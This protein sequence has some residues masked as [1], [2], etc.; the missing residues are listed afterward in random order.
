[1]LFFFLLLSAAKG[2]QES[3]QLLSLHEPTAALEASSDNGVPM[4]VQVEAEYLKNVSDSVLMAESW[5]RNFVLPHYPRT[6]ISTIIVGHSVLCNSVEEDKLGLIL[7]SIKNIH[8]SLTRWGLE[9]EIKVAASFSSNCLS[10]EAETH[11]K[12]LLNLLQ[13]MGSPYVVNPPPNFGKWSDETSSLVKS[14][15]ESMKNMGVSGLKTVNVVVG[16][17]RKHKPSGRKLSFID[18][19]RNIVPFPPRPTPIAPYVSPPRS[20]DPA[21]AA[22]SPL[23]PLVGTVS[24]TPLSLPSLPPTAANPTNPPFLPH[25]APMA[26]PSSP[27][28]GLHLPPCDPSNGGGSVGAPV[29]GVH[30]GLWCVAKP[31]VPAETLQEAIDYACGEG[32]ADCEAISHGGS[33]YFPDTV[34]A[35]ASYAFNSYWQ[36]TKKHGGTCGFGGTAMLINSDPSK[37]SFYHY[38]D[39]CL[40]NLLIE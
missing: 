28:F 20:S 30:N 26:N 15:L 36:R 19:I 16:S 33:C 6:N 32:G 21:F 5:L 25:L 24:P 10:E 14:H 1:M 3:V 2:Q 18:I 4:A 8:S 7:P 40:F 37:T 34:V 29:A 27:P 12:P 35:H 11:I 9:R 13:E 22:G 38:L 39:L 31:T 23:P 17:S